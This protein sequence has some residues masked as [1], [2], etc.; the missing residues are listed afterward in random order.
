MNK[1]YDID[2]L[3]INPMFKIHILNTRLH[4]LFNSKQLLINIK[5]YDL[6]VSIKLKLKWMKIGF[7]FG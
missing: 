1:F 6:S 7:R 3:K 5:K 2:I 4:S